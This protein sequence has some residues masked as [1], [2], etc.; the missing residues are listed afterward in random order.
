MQWSDVIKP[1]SP[2]I[3][4]QFAGLFLIEFLVM[5]GLRWYRGHAD[6]WAV[7]LATVAVVVG[8]TG[9]VAPAVIRPIY[10]GW[11]IAAFPIGW[12]VSRVVLGGMFFIVLTPVGWFFRLT[13]RDALRLRSQPRQSDWLPKQQPSS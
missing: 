7:G 11:M 10:S 5:A 1:P 2:K 3:L 6:A 9:L 4:R 13:G 12:T 8:V